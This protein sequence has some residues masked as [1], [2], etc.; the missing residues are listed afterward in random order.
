MKYLLLILLVGG[1]LCSSV[2]QDIYSSNL[3]VYT[4][5]G[6]KFYLFLNGVRQN[7]LPE[8]L[9]KVTSIPLFDVNVRVVYEDTMLKAVYKK[10]VVVQD[11]RGQD[12]E[13]RY[14]V[15]TSPEKIKSLVLAI[16]M[17][18]LV[19]PDPPADMMVVPFNNKI[20]PHIITHPLK[21][22]TEGIKPE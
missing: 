3:V 18:K 17:P 15:T 10:G 6:Q 21:S 4:E 7:V 5:D 16:S 19:A 14:H 8:K 20:M 12:L 13:V 22:S 11:D 1:S 2:A 9:I